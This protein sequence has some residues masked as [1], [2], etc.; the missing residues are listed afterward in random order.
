MIDEPLPGMPADTQ[1]PGGTPPEGV[2][3][4]RYTPRTRGLCGDCIADIHRLGAAVAPY[5]QA[6]R[7]QVSRGSLTLH[8]CDRHTTERLESWS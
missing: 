2:T 4:R 6:S 8:L 5:P 1:Q 3:R 7:W